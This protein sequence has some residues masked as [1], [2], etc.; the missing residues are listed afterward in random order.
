MV[1]FVFLWPDSFGFS[2]PF[3]LKD[4]AVQVYE[5]LKVPLIIFSTQMR[6][7]SFR[8]KQVQ[9]RSLSSSFQIPSMTSKIT[10][11]QSKI[12]I[13]PSQIAQMVQIFSTAKA[14]SLLIQIPNTTTQIFSALMMWTSFRVKQVSFPQPK[15]PKQLRCSL[16][17]NCDSAP[18]SDTYLLLRPELKDIL[19][20]F[21]TL[22]D[23]DGF[24][25]LILSLSPGLLVYVSCDFWY[26]FSLVCPT[27]ICFSVQNFV[28]FVDPWILNLNFLLRSLSAILSIFSPLSGGFSDSGIFC[29]LD[30]ASFLAKGTAI[31][32][33]P[34]QSLHCYFHFQRAQVQYVKKCDIFWLLIK[35]YFVNTAYI[36]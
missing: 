21:V 14:A 2:A 16:R 22:E 23:K 20:Y 33:Q 7:T 6:E 28:I 17:G 27:H 18:P 35:A 32:R 12:K 9:F 10:T 15:Q 8:V 26:I 30:N 29:D 34:K 5:L 24:L 1:L 13:T 19:W 3:L 11:T 31:V 4:L 25:I 36:F